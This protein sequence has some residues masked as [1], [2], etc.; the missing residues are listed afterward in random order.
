MN[1]YNNGYEIG[2]VLNAISILL[3]Y[4]NLQENRQQSEYNDVHKANDEQA[5]RLLQEINE[6][7]EEQNI[8]LM[9]IRSKVEYIATKIGSIEKYIEG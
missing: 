1:I 3:G 4:Q 9:D 8:I 6:K 5:E 2:D 7:F